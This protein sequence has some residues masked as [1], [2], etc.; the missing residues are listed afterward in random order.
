MYRADA[1]LGMPPRELGGRRMCQT[2][3]SREANVLCQG[4]W[5]AVRTAT[6]LGEPPV[7]W[8]AFRG[9]RSGM[10]GGDMESFVTELVD[11]LYEGALSPE[12]RQALGAATRTEGSGK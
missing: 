2:G 3:P 8:G 11:I 4:G 7:G 6:R 12:G 9:Y 10:V 5:A 1:P